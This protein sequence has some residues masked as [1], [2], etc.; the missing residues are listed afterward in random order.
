VTY[1]YHNN[2]NAATSF[3]TRYVGDLDPLL[4]SV[5]LLIRDQYTTQASDCVPNQF[6]TNQVAVNINV[7]D[8]TSASVPADSIQNASAFLRPGATAIVTARI[9][10]RAGAP[11]LKLSKEDVDATFGLVVKADGKTRPTAALDHVKPRFT[12][13]ADIVVPSTSK[14]GAIVT[15]DNPSVLDRVDAVLGIAVTS[16][17]ASATGLT[18]GSLFPIGTTTIICTATDSHG[19]TATTDFTITVTKKK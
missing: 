9:R 17:C 11:K 14:D 7:A 6:Q 10:A 19:N 3:R 16:S 12:K 1:T 13:K 4:Y 18:S 2:G 8:V 15:F 5:Q